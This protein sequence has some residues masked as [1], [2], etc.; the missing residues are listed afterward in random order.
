[1][2]QTYNTVGETLLSYRNS[3][4]DTDVPSD[5]FDNNNDTY[6][7]LK[8]MDFPGKKIINLLHCNLICQYIEKSYVLRISKSIKF[9]VPRNQCDPLRNNWKHM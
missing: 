3:S 6:I 1:M 5:Q 2:L 8:K 9:Y 7:S 4:D